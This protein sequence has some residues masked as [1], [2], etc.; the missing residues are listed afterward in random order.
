MLKVLSGGISEPRHPDHAHSVQVISG[1]F[2]G[3]QQPPT[4]YFSK[5]KSDEGIPHKIRRIDPLA[6]HAGQ[7]AVLNVIRLFLLIEAD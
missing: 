5:S 1:G 4:A 3:M 7:G 2:S 6:P